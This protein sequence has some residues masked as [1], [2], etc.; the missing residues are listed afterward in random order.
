M[1]IE[2]DT[3]NFRGKEWICLD[4]LISWLREN[5]S[6]CSGLEPEFKAFLH[7]LIKEII[8]MKNNTRVKK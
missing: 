3:L 6:E 2:I 8:K 7:F 5:Q 4:D 1:S